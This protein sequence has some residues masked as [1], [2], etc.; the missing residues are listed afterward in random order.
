M[1]HRQ[2]YAPWVDARPPARHAPPQPVQNLE[3]VLLCVCVCVCVVC[4]GNVAYEYGER[5]TLNAQAREARKKDVR[6]HAR[7]RSGKGA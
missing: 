7:T 1:R 2:T 4:I 5:Q 6:M 3:A